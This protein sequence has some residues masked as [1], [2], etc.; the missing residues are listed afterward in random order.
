MVRGP[1][2]PRPALAVEP[3]AISGLGLGSHV[4]ADAGRDGEALFRAI[5]CAISGCRVACQCSAGR[6]DAP[7]V[8][9]WLLRAGAEPQAWSR[10]DRRAAR[11]LSSRDAG[12][13]DGA[14]RH[15]T[16]DCGRDPR[17]RAWPASPDPRRQ[18]QARA[19]ARLSGRRSARH[20][21]RRKKA[22]GA[23]AR[24]H[25]ACT[26]RGIHAGDHGSRSH[27]LHAHKPGLHELSAGD[28]LRRIGCRPRWRDTRRAAPRTA[29]P[30]ADAHGV[31]SVGRPR[32]ARA[33]PAARNLGRSLGAAGVSGCG[34]GRGL[35][36]YPIRS[37]HCFNPEAAADPT[38]FHAFRS[39]Y[40]A[41]AA[42]TPG[43]RWRGGGGRIAVA[44]TCVD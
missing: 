17:A 11:R 12:R 5:H 34:R 40:R 18:R 21:R 24:L 38:R 15:R 16:L 42:G 44:R 35:R 2:P 26:R 4:A 28:W 7:L 39:R 8:G 19:C 43:A 1:W 36:G 23:G 9:S 25:A 22:L 29:A 31:R 41:L 37:G 10:G 6:S 3:D 14:S 32:D 13:P 33:A 20:H 30:A 27:G